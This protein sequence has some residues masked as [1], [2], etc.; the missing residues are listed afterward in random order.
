[1]VN[2]AIAEALEQGN[3]TE[4]DTESD[5]EIVKSL[6]TEF[7]KNMDSKLQEFNNRF[8]KNLQDN[9]N[10]KNHVDKALQNESVEKNENEYSTKSI[11]EKIV[12][13]N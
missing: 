4:S 11:A 13:M 2:T 8:F 7:N 10:P 6:L 9:R 12:S 5:D 3:K 1:M